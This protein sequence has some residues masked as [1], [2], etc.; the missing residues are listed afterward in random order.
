[1]SVD[2]KRFIIKIFIAALI[3]VFLGWIVFSFITPG[4]YIPVLP[5]ILGFF[6]LMTIVLHACQ[7]RLAKKNF[8]K[9]TRTS[10]LVSMFRLLLY[11]AV[12]I[13]FLAGR[14]DDIA[15]F[16]VS[17][18]IIYIVFTSIEVSD[19]SRIVRKGN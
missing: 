12:T 1:M 5:Y 16:V 10:M 15:V 8:Q 2:L 7:L 6:I 9:F 11:S 4:N 17:I 19:L 18:V 3:L 14:P 13:L